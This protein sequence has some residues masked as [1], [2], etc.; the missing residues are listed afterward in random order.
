MGVSVGVSV[1][2]WLAPA[3]ADPRTTAHNLLLA[4]ASTLTDDPALTHDETG[5]PQIPGLAVSLTHTH[6]QVAVAA[7]PEGPVGLDL[8]ELGP[9]EFRP[10]ADRWFSQ[11]EL[12]W[13][14]QQPDVRRAFLQLWTAKEA[15]GKALGLGLRRAGLR[16]P[17]PL[18][19]GVVASAPE[20]LVTYVPWPD[21]VLALAA[22]TGLTE[23][24]VRH[25]TALRSV[26]RS[27]TSLPVVVRGS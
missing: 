16:R 4:L 7:A 2:V 17:M 5:R 22:P 23:I 18:G 11:Q 12:R 8:E 3:G 27:R 15:V 25:E 6:H 26:V 13:L 1:H 19:G 21:A 14:D 20:L 24:V 9:R 10:L